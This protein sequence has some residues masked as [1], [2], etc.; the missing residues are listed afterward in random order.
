MDGTCQH[1]GVPTC[2]LC[3]NILINS[4]SGPD[5]LKHMGMHILHDHKLYS[6]LSPCSFCLNS[7]CKIHLSRH[8]QFTIID[9]QKS[10]CPNLQKVCLKIAESFIEHQPCTNHPLKCLLCMLIVWKY[11]LQNHITD[12]HPNANTALYKSLYRLHPSESTLMKGVFLAPTHSTKSKRSKA[13][14]LTISAGH[15][16]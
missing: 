1:D 2:S 13:K 5:L 4:L 15:S 7:Q 11:N 8:G 6:R 16:S 9:M 3:P 12:T 14:A 10:C